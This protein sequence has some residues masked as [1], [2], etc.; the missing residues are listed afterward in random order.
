MGRASVLKDTVH[1]FGIHDF[2][3]VGLFVDD[4][5]QQRF[6]FIKQGDVATGILANSHL[7][8]AHG[9]A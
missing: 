2:S 1:I 4:G 6:L 8:L 7:G 3:L 9:I 5:I